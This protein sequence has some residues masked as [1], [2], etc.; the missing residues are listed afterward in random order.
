MQRFSHE[1]NKNQ[2]NGKMILFREL[3]NVVAL[4]GWIFHGILF[5]WVT[6]HNKT[7][8]TKNNGINYL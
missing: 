4:E 3:V 7:I 8:D 2:T 5:D 1:K 6:E